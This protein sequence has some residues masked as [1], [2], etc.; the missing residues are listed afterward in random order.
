MS[1]YP[2]PK[3]P[4]PKYA[5]PEYPLPEH[6]V[7]DA[8]VPVSTLPVTAGPDSMRYP[9]GAERAA[10]AVLPLS[11]PAPAHVLQRAL[12]EVYVMF[13]R[14]RSSY[15]RSSAV[16]D[17]RLDAALTGSQGH[18]LLHYFNSVK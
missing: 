3:Y 4:L 7:P 1:K 12:K 8:A 6:F 2:L 5:R 16:R 15:L 17:A 18:L 10:T 11:P 14:L 13:K 9:A